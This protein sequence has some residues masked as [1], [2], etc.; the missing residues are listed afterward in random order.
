MI[1]WK[2]LFWVTSTIGLFTLFRKIIPTRITRFIH[3]GVATMLTLI[4]ILLIFNVP[5]DEYE[6]ASR[7]ISVF[8]GPAVVALAVP[9][10]RYW[11]MPEFSRIRK[12][13]LFI[14]L[15]SSFVG[16]STGVFLARLMGASREVVMAVAPKSITSP[17]AIP[18]LERFQGPSELSAVLIFFIG[19]FGVMI[20][21]FLFHIFKIE[22]D[23]AQGYALGSA[24]HGL[25]TAVSFEKS[26]KSGAMAT[27]GLGLMG[28]WTSLLFS[29]AMVLGAI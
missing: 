8:L 15:I 18:L 1:V 11:L 14:S 28:V 2:E 26:E 13:I 22:S 20:A 24:A 5:L 7:W 12:K 10:A 25:G 29:I 21:P 16:L 6:K 23:I 4:G 19:V 9:L 3:P 27:L 17:I